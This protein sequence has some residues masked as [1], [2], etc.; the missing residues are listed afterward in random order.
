MYGRDV[1]ALDVYVKDVCTDNKT[2]LWSEHNGKDDVWIYHETPLSVV[3][4][5]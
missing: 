1:T 2:L 3:S 4:S 5:R